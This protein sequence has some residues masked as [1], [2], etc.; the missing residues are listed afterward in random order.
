MFEETG[1]ASDRH[2]VNLEQGERNKPDYLAVNPNGKV[3]A[4]VDC[5]GSGGGEIVV[6]ASGAILPYLADNSGQFPTHKMNTGWRAISWLMLQMGGIGPSLVQGGCFLNRAPER[7]PHA[8]E[9]FVRE[10][11]RLYRFVDRQLAETAYLVG[12]Y[13]IAGIACFP[14]IRSHHRFRVEIADSPDVA[15]WLGTISARPAVRRVVS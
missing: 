6:F 3:P 8:V 14:W 15:R 13:S 10:A 9:R 11:E 5:S 2:P 7:V 1:L 4:T 12:E